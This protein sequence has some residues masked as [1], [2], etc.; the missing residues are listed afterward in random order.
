MALYTTSADIANRALQLIGATA[1]VN[2]TDLNKNAVACNFFY[3]KARALELRLHPWNFAVKYT[4]LSAAAGTV[5]Y[6]NG[7]TR[8]QFT[9]PT[10][11]ARLADQNPRAAGTTVQTVSAATKY[12]DYAVEGGSLVTATAAPIHLRY[13][14]LIST[15]TLFDP[16]FCEALAAMMAM[17]LIPL[18]TQSPQKFQLAQSYYAFIIAEAKRA[19]L[20]EAGADEPVE[21]MLDLTRMNT[22]ELPTAPPPQRGRRG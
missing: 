7:Q 6:Q 11:Y 3:D 9:L 22:Q 21:E 5:T 12:T 13:I 8:S 18:L 10:D 16:L 14:G 4:T 17:G 19:N 20:I 1:I 2:I 15:V